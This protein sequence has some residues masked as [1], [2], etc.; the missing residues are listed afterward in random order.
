[1]AFQFHIL[2]LHSDGQPCHQSH[3]QHTNQVE[4]LAHYISPYNQMR[5]LL[6]PNLNQNYIVHQLLL[7]SKLNFLDK[8]DNH[9]KLHHS[10][11]LNLNHCLRSLQAYN[12]QLQYRVLHQNN[13]LKHHILQALRPRFLPDHLHRHQTTMFEIHHLH[14]ECSNHQNHQVQNHQN[15]PLHNL[16]NNYNQNLYYRQCK[17]HNH[18]ILPIPKFHLRNL[19]QYSHMFDCLQFATF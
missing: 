11:N 12:M 5:Y 14:L 9:L 7:Q 19:D 4:G 3:S 17:E 15:I 16:N 6:L 1:M 8:F 13:H 18:P 2:L 10:L